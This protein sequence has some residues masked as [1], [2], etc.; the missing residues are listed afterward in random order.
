MSVSRLCIAQILRTRGKKRI[1]RKLKYSAL[2][3]FLARN[4]NLR[5][6]DFLTRKIEIK[7][8]NL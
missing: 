6:Y 5:I 1:K 2:M 8:I 7:K 4:L 3:M